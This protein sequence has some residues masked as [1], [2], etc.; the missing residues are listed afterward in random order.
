MLPDERIY[1]ITKGRSGPV[2]L[3]RFPLPLDTAGSNPLQAVQQLTPGL[4]QLPDMVTGAAATPDGRVVAVR[5]YSALQLYRL[6]NDQLTPLTNVSGFD[7][8][9][10][11]EPQGEGIDIR[12]DGTIF[13]VS[14][15]GLEAGPAPISRVQ[16]AWSAE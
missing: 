3:Y 13:L 7:L 16:C 5:T 9:P 4:V 10:L 11:R 15:K 8:Q 6:Q 12:A 14:E 2:T 1:L